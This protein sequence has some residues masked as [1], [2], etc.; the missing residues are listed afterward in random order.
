MNK[1]QE[2]YNEENRKAL[3]DLNQ[4]VQSL[5]KLL[6]GKLEINQ[7]LTTKIDNQIE[8]VSVNNLNELK[9]SLLQVSETIKTAVEKNK[10]VKEVRVSNLTKTEAVKINNLA[11]LKR[12]FDSLN[13][14]IKDNQPVVN[15]TKQDIVFPNTRKDYISVRL[16]D[17]DKFYKAISM[18]ASGGIASF[19]NSSG[20]ATQVRLNS[21]GS[22]PTSA[23]TL[24]SKIYDDGSYTY[25]CEAD[26]G[27][28]LSASAWR[29]TRYDSDGSSTHP[30]GST[31]F[32]NA[33]T[34]VSTVQGYTY[35]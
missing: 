21:D 19:M 14:V 16:T 27:T 2:L 29:I 25:I 22:V 26:A 9:D 3:I 10:P 11:E 30:S 17:G 18:A 15:V 5:I 6:S 4:G 8:E 12:Y 24:K 35:S 34:N 20:V 33:V 28:A 13:K 23:P 32:N 7:P 1:E 31:A